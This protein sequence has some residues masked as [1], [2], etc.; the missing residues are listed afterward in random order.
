[1]WINVGDDATDSRVAVYVFGSGGANGENVQWKNSKIQRLRLESNKLE[2]GNSE[3][4][5]KSE[6]N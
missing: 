2:K 6:E 1:M 5:N 3:N 4:V